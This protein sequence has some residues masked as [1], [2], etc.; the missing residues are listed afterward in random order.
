LTAPLID[1]GIEHIRDLIVSGVLPPGSR[2]PP[3]AELAAVLGC[4]RGTTRE[5]VRSLVMAKVLDVRRGDGTYVT[6]LEPR[7]LLEGISFAID[8]IS[9]EDLLEL[10]ELRRL[11]EPP[12]IARAASRIDDLDLERLDKALAEMRAAPDVDQLVTH[13][14]EFHDIAAQA[15]GN[16]TLAGLLASVSSRMTRARIWHGV[17]EEGENANTLLQHGEILA[18][19]RAHD[20]ERA[21]AAALIHVANSEAWLRRLV[22]SAPRGRGP[23]RQG[24]VPRRATT[25]RAA[26]PARRAPS[27]SK[28]G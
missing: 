17:R 22:T 4:S 2:L 16:G 20:P 1:Q 23:A 15:A 6:S 9:D 3:E 19:L 26:K 27:S 11:V 21:Q 24:E 25:M 5:A 12:T 28:Q 8:L 7:L 10:W 13:D 18:A 14:A